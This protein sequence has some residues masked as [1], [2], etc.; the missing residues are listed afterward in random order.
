[1][2]MLTA[3]GDALRCTCGCSKASHMLFVLH[4]YRTCQ[5]NAVCMLNHLLH[6]TVLLRCLDAHAALWHDVGHGPFSH[7]FESCFL[8]AV[9]G[10]HCW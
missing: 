3:L 7:T 6:C 9:R 1:M 8:P 4:Q 2:V 10:N 5:R